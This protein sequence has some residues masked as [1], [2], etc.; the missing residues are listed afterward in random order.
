MSKSIQ[1]CL[2]LL[3]LFLTT[4][5]WSR[6]FEAEEVAILQREL[7]GELPQSEL[8][9]IFSSKR[10]EKYDDIF[11]LNITKPINLTMNRYSHFVEPYA[12]GLAKKFRRRWRTVLTRA[13]KKFGVDKDIIVG[14]LLVETSF[15]RFTGNYQLL[16]IFSSLVVDLKTWEQD[17]GQKSK[18]KAL[19]KRVARKFNWALNELKALLKIKKKYPQWDL[20]K[21]KG[22]YAGAFGK[23]QFLPS[24]YL[25]FAVSYKNTGMPNLHFEADAIYSI[26]NYLKVNGYRSPFTSQGCRDALFH[27]NRSQVYAQTIINVAKKLKGMKISS[28]K[29]GKAAVKGELKKR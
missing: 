16:S 28:E 8:R 13:Q 10:I 17:Q 27:Y 26:A 4:L 19:K 23:S 5:A 3:Y 14:V 22:S 29:K 2:V 6:G 11:G 12:I 15:G 18:D 21:V 20:Y 7:K 9:K 1:L 24:S 25:R